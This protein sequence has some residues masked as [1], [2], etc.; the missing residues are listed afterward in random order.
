MNSPYLIIKEEGDCLTLDS[1]V[2][3][4]SMAEAMN[5]GARLK[6]FD[7]N[8]DQRWFVFKGCEIKE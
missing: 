7:L 3:A 5:H 4:S 1:I 2:E 8:P 6:I